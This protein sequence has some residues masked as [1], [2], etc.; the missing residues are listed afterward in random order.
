MLTNKN[1]AITL[2]KITIIRFQIL[3]KFPHGSMGIADFILI[4]TELI[5]LSSSFKKDNLFLD[6]FPYF[7]Y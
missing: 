2:I 1:Q 4:K 5:S 3:C 6:D 7:L